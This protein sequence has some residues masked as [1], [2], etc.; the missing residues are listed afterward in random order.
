MHSYTIGIAFQTISGY[1]ALVPVHLNKLNISTIGALALN[2]TYGRLQS[3]ANGIPSR[4]QTPERPGSSTH[5]FRGL[6]KS[7]KECGFFIV[8]GLKRGS[9]TI[10]IIPV[11]SLSSGLPER[12]TTH[13]FI[14]DGNTL[15]ILVIEGLV[16]ILVGFLISRYVLNL[17]LI[18]ISEP[19]RPY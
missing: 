16:A 19:T 4:Q 1:P 10:H 14:M 8:R 5:D 2:G 7:W 15:I 9:R 13:Q 3:R 12:L 6:S 17:S 18:H 11:Y